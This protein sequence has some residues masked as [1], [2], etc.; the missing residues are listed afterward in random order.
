MN[1][2]WQ[3]KEDGGEAG[4]S[5]KRYEARIDV[6]KQKW[7]SNWG[8]INQAQVLTIPLTSYET[9]GRMFCYYPVGKI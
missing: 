3:R 5:H 1:D 2:N 4:A 7:N 6:E 8:W 9:M